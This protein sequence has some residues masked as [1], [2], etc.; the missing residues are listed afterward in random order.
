[1][2]R[3]F[4]IFIATICA[5]LAFVGCGEVE[6]TGVAPTIKLVETE[7]TEN[8]ISFVIGTSDAKECAYMLYDGDVTSVSEVFSKGTVVDGNGGFYVIDGLQSGTKYHVI[9]A[10]RNSVGEALSNTLVVTTKGVNNGGNGGNDDDFELPEIE[11]VENV[12]I[13]KTQDG[14]WY[15][16][17]N[18]YV[19]F[20]CDN[21]DR[22][23]LDFYTLDE[24][25][26]QYFPYGQ[27]ENETKSHA[28]SLAGN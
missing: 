24:T 1:M 25:M 4:K 3:L 16:P 8:S 15:K 26:S 10:A 21:G 22:I 19:T 11:G 9:A 12:N 14:R 28:S 13:V 18:Y 5:T 27:Y 20:V 6:K 23:I 2:N 7:V 17:Y